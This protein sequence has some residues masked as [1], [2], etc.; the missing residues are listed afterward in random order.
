LYTIAYLN[1]LIYLLAYN[2]LIPYLINYPIDSLYNEKLIFFFVS[3]PALV[4]VTD[5]G[6]KN[7]AFSWT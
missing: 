1:L 7:V 6:M 4:K 3:N 2:P 5:D